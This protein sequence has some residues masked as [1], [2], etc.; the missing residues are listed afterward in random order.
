MNDFYSYLPQ[1]IRQ[2]LNAVFEAVE[3]SSSVQNKQ[4][5]LSLLPSAIRGNLLQKGKKFQGRI[6]F[7]EEQS[8][9]RI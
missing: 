4:V 7:V 9:I 5:L 6:R 3:I 2:K 8:G 1:K